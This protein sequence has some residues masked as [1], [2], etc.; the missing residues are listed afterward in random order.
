MQAIR[1]IL[2]CAFAA[3]ALYGDAAAQTA[4]QAADVP[5]SA[6][7]APM[8]GE[9]V[10]TPAQ[11]AAYTR[12]AEAGDRMA[13]LRLARA[14]MHG[15]GVAKD[16]AQARV[17]LGRFLATPDLRAPPDP[18]VLR[19]QQAA[20]PRIQQENERALQ[21]KEANRSAE[22]LVVFRRLQPEAVRE[23]GWGLNTTVAVTQNLATTLQDE[24]LL[25]EALGTYLL[26]R[27]QAA[28][29]LRE[30]GPGPGNVAPALGLAAIHGNLATLYQQFGDFDAAL[31][32]WQA[33]VN[34]R[35]EHLGDG[36][37]LAH[38]LLG[39]A[40]VLHR[41]GRQQEALALKLQ[42]REMLERTSREPRSETHA[43]VLG[44]LC[45]SL[46]EAGR[47]AEATPLCE[48]A[49]RREEARA[50]ERSESLFGLLGTLADNRRSSGEA[51]AELAL[52]VRALGLAEASGRPDNA[53]NANA[54]LAALFERRGNVA[55]ATLFAGRAVELSQQM[56]GAFGSADRLADDFVASRADTYRLLARL[57]LA[58]G[59]T[60]D[61]LE[62]LDLLRRSEADGFVERRAPAV[63]LPPGLPDERA[64]VDGFV[65]ATRRLSTLELQAGR[66]REIARRS[67][68]TAP[69]HAELAA[70]D[71]QIAGLRISTRQ[72]IERWRIAPRPAGKGAAPRT[73]QATLP[74]GALLLGY[75]IGDDGSYAYWSRGGPPQTRALALTRAQLGD[76]L[77]KL[78]TQID[79]RSGNPLP[80]LRELHRMLVEP[81]ADQLEAPH[82]VLA[83]VD[84]VRFVPFAA[85][86]DGQDF[87]V[88]RFAFQSLAGGGGGP[89]TTPPARMT[90]LGLSKASGGMEPLPGVVAEL[91]GIVRGP[92]RGLPDPGACSRW[93]G[94]FERAPTGEGFLDAEF[95]ESRL[96]GAAQ[97]GGVLHVATHFTLGAIDSQS[98]LT[99]DGRRLGLDTLRDVDFSR[100]ALL[101]L[102]ACNTA[103]VSGG[104]QFQGL[105][106]FMLE[107]GA[108]RV[109]A[110]QWRASDRGTPLLMRAFYERLAQ[111]PTPPAA[112][113]LRAA[114]LTLLSHAEGAER[115]FAHPYY[116][117]GFVLFEGDAAR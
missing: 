116:W 25:G 2:V 55:A 42:A 54:A 73:L 46:T 97:A 51:D 93:S 92:V 58:Q 29:M 112:H 34:L 33:S 37:W 67:P 66:L 91:C 71:S 35:R 26:A 13:M 107:R 21:L 94:P 79:R 50:G 6:L 75:V 19:R 39:Q 114:Q 16:E 3:L 24:G 32:Q 104:S 81:I 108:G 10:P 68:G 59:R 38:S 105:A 53:W 99:L 103:R 82:I 20:L 90:A 110:T 52:R 63:A 83:A 111:D 102:S 12:Q 69:V 14:Y 18:E 48:D 44:S 40:I 88:R 5:L 78:Y 87:L 101:T 36:R 89:R 4:P 109:I 100:T 61:A 41:L 1:R 56:R 60:A 74:P 62:V 115:P 76:L 117:A 106:S 8:P 7:P 28:A 64:A 70:V 45:Y 72:Q 98:F 47:A 31:Q 86:H 17:W 9:P 23:L 49:V 11:L 77:V 96:R 95:T 84:D 65:A 85:L 57:L 27:D 80:E 22:A 30:R 43:R 113:A 15:I